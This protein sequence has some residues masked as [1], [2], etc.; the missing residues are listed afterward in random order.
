LQLF[1]RLNVILI[2]D[3]ASVKKFLFRKNFAEAEEAEEAEE[4]RRL[5]LRKKIWPRK[6]LL[7][8]FLFRLEF[9]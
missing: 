7:N 9:S 6:E 3:K 2:S 4:L 1:Y 8:F 5:D